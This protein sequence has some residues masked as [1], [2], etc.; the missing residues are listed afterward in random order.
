MNEDDICAALWLQEDARCLYLW[1][2]NY[3][4]K[5]DAVNDWL[6]VKV[7]ENAAHSSREARRYAGVE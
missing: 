3:R 1:A 2:R 4:D 5:G 6:A 7:Q